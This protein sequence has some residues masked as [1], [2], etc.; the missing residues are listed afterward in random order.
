MFSLKQLYLVVIRGQGRW[1][2]TGDDYNSRYGTDLTARAAAPQ[3]PKQTFRQVK[4]FPSDALLLPLLPRRAVVSSRT[5]GQCD[6]IGIS[7][8]CG[9]PISI[10]GWEPKSVNV[11]QGHGGSQ[12]SPCRN[13]ENLTAPLWVHKQP[14]SHPAGASPPALGESQGAVWSCPSPAL[15]PGAVEQHI[16]QHSPY[17][18]HYKKVS[19]IK[20]QLKKISI[21]K[22][23]DCTKNQVALVELKFKSYSAAYKI[24]GKKRTGSISMKMV[25]PCDTPLSPS[26]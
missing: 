16:P 26:H 4:V 17:P 12:P 15:Q 23:W 22:S 10:L 21:R 24:R 14:I 5:A 25:H 7:A 20:K 8:Q 19:L 18:H 1:R 13:R 3:P 9:H 11:R 6:G 2:L